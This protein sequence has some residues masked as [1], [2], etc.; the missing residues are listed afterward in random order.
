MPVSLDWDL[1]AIVEQWAL[2]TEWQD[3]FDNTSLDEGDIVRI[4]R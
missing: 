4:L 3:L 1:I 2:E